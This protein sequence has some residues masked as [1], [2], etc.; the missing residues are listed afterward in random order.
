MSLQ[1]LARELDET[2]RQSAAM[3]EGITEALE[4]LTDSTAGKDAS[5]RQAMLMIE[6]RLSH[7]DLLTDISRELGIS[8]RQLER[9]F[10]AD[11]AITPRNYRLKLRLARARW[12]IEHTDASLTD[13][14][15]EC[16]FGNCSHCSRAFTSHFKASPS[17]LRRTLRVPA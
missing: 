9:R 1:K 5:V 3:L 2:A 10:I 15:F 17:S 12:M 6:Q 16:G 8:M 11:V 7:P 4:L 14:G 13:I